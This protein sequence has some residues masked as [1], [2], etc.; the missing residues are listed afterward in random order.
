MRH[1]MICICAISVT[2]V[3]CNLSDDKVKPF[4]VFQSKH[5]AAVK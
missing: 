3:L 4:T 5:D 1:S 2:S